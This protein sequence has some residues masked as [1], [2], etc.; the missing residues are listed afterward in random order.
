M[1]STGVLFGK[2]AAGCAL[3]PPRVMTPRS[4]LAPPQLTPLRFSPPLP[5]AARCRCRIV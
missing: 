2:L 5:D 1:D 4:H 3:G